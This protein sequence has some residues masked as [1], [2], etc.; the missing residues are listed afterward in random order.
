MNFIVLNGR[1][2]IISQDIKNDIDLS[3]VEEVF[4][5]NIKKVVIDSG[6]VVSIIDYKNNNK[7]ILFK[8]VGYDF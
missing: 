3:V 8:K 4:K 5:D 7:L 2:E 1:N 6:I